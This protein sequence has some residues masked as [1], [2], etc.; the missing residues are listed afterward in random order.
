M[1]F[2]ILSL[3]LFS[4]LKKVKLLNKLIYNINEH[5]ATDHF[6]LVNHTLL[7][8]KLI[9]YYELSTWCVHICTVY[10]C[11][12]WVALFLWLFSTSSLMALFTERAHSA[13]HSWFSNVNIHIFATSW[14]QG[15][16]GSR[17]GKRVFI[18]IL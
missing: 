6:L 18:R 8:T 9:R 11:V 4:K 13:V 14:M 16:T 7:K 1:T 12:I 5:T 3:L 15:H 17:F 2:T 10:T